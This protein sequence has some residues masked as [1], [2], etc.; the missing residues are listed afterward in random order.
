MANNFQTTTS[1]AQYYDSFNGTAPEGFPSNWGVLLA[2][3]FKELSLIT[4]ADG[5]SVLCETRNPLVIKVNPSGFWGTPITTSTSFRVSAD[6]MVSHALIF[7][8]FRNDSCLTVVTQSAAGVKSVLLEVGLRMKSTVPSLSF[9]YQ[10]FSA[11]PNNIDVTVDLTGG[12]GDPWAANNWGRVGFEVMGRTITWWYDSAAAANLRHGA[13]FNGPQNN[14]NFILG[15]TQI[16][17]VDL[18]SPLWV[19]CRFNDDG[20]NYTTDDAS[21]IGFC[22]MDCLLLESGVTGVD[23]PEFIP[24]FPFN[25]YGLYKSQL[26]LHGLLNNAKTAPDTTF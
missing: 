25:P 13:V 24:P 23:V 17:T 21:P 7:P 22:A 20:S 3:N 26:T 6:V 14:A 2:Q 12:A 18:P 11:A 4:T 16:M 1:P 5:E 10:N 9:H 8:N 15:S 19:G